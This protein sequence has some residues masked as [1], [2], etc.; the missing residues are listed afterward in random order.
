MQTA[1]LCILLLVLFTTLCYTLR[2]LKYPTANEDAATTS[3][4]DI[5][6][7]SLDMPR[8]YK[9]PVEEY[10][11]QRDYNY[12]ALPDHANN[13]IAASL[14]QTLQQDH[15]QDANNFDSQMERM[16]GKATIGKNRDAIIPSYK[17]HK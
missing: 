3:P 13:L 8:D 7:A 10:M 6:A 15:A 11:T 12:R 9:Y 17:Y 16:I 1:R 2:T 5:P 4:L 14:E